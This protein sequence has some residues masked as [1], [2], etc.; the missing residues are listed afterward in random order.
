M[1]LKSHFRFDRNQQSGILL[2][3][4][5]IVVLIGFLYFYNFSEDT[6]FDTTSAEVIAVQ[7]EIDSLKLTEIENRKP[8][9]YPFNPNYITDFKAYTIGMKPAEYDR[10][11]AFRSEKKW[12]NSSEDF[13]RVTGVSDSLLAVISPYFK[14]PEW[15]INKKNNSEYSE[16][17]SQNNF[18][19]KSDNIIMS[20]AKKTD[21][22]SAT[23]EELQRVN[24]I[25]EALGKRIVEFR[26]KNKGFINDVQL[27][28]VYGLNES[29]IQKV[30][31]QFTVKTPKQIARSDLNKA[32]ASDIAT[33]PG[34]SFEMG[35]EIW[36]FRKLRGRL[37][38]FAELEKIDGLTAQ[39]LQLIQ[40]YL[41]IE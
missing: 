39:K 5:L 28:A 19:K 26:D 10:L 13:K 23:S 30:L 3:L 27:N 29:T 2:L 31:Q 9:L 40:L 37:A 12:I 34:I 1:N 36:Q 14:F 4:L 17:K 22:N 11:K 8:K 25:G 33:I 16:N 41:Y 15:V 7:K 18:S 24:G 20:F 38:S 35:K 32:T 21:L 6:V